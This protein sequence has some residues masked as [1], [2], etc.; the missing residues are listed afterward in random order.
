MYPMTLQALNDAS[1][2]IK[3]VILQG[4]RSCHRMTTLGSCFTDWKGLIIL[5][6]VVFVN[7]DAMLMQAVLIKV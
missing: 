3:V 7:L 6:V 4:P 5:V 1:E 2:V